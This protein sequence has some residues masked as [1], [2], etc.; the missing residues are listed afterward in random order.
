[1]ANEATHDPRKYVALLFGLHRSQATGVLSVK[2]GRS[3]RRFYL[4]AGKVLRAESS[5]VAESLARSLQEAGLVQRNT[6][7]RLSADDLAA[8]ELAQVLVREE[9]LPAD[10]LAKHRGRLTERI[11]GAS[12]GWK[13]G[14]WSFDD[15]ASRITLRVDPRLFPDCSIPHALWSGTR[16]A[17]TMQG[18][19]DEVS[20]PS[21][22]DIVPAEGLADALAS[23]AVE[24]PLDGLPEKLGGGVDVAELYRRLPDR[25]GHLAVLLWLLEAGC[26]VTR[27]GRPA[28]AELT[29]LAAGRLPEEALGSADLDELSELSGP[30]EVEVELEAELEVELDDEPV[31]VPEPPP[32]PKTSR[33]LSMPARKLAK[34]VRADHDH[35]IGKDYYAFLDLPR[36]AKPADIEHT[37]QGLR[38]PW[39]EAAGNDAVDADIEALASDL[40]AGVQLVLSTLCD[41]RK[42]RDYDRRLD[43]GEPPVVNGL[44]RVKPRGVRFSSPGALVPGGAPLRPAHMEARKLIQTGDFPGAIARLSKLRQDNPS[45]VDVLADLGWASWKADRDPD[46]LRLAVTFDASNPRALEYL[47]RVYEELG[48]PDKVAKIARSL[49]KVE[50]GN[51]WAKQAS[52]AGAEGRW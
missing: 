42:R 1:M 41:A 48:Q 7:R 12:M 51:A 14:Q 6:L 4:H 36:G 8:D 28:P 23:M 11:L 21:A 50:R 19:I 52:A 22:G 29:D 18:V 32:P 33:P 13:S 16:T 2:K 37:V 45:D 30:V 35:R 34:V 38:T 5:V 17:V 39:D 46:Y 27:S 3:W 43:K 24:A 15:H 49:L 25:S 40:V 47:G 44:S 20:D 9:H 31:F 26:L 10:E